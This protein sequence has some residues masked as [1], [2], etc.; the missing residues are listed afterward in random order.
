MQPQNA[1]KEL[2]QIQNQ[3]HERNYDIKNP[4]TQYLRYKQLINSQYYNLRANSEGQQDLLLNDPSSKYGAIYGQTKKVYEVP[5]H[6]KLS[7][8]Q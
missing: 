7:E 3:I 5:N 2:L 1:E 8:L 6:F 4:D